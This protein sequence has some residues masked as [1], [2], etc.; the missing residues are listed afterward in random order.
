MDMTPQPLS[1]AFS[2]DQSAGLNAALFEHLFKIAVDDCLMILE[3]PV[4]EVKIELGAQLH[5][6]VQL[7]A[8][9]RRRISE[10]GCDPKRIEQW[11][12]SVRSGS[13]AGALQ[14]RRE[15]IFAIA[16]LTESS[17]AEIHETWDEP[18][19]RLLHTTY[20]QL[21]KLAERM[22]KCY[23]LL[24][25]VLAQ[26]ALKR[27]IA[28]DG[29]TPARDHRFSVSDTLSSV[30][31]KSD[32]HAILRMCHGTLMGTEIPTI[33]ACVDL[34]LEFHDVDFEFVLDM[35]RQTWDEAR[36]ARA[37]IEK[38]SELGGELGAFPT[39]FVLWQMSRSEDLALRLCIHQRIGEWIGVDAALGLV[40]DLRQKND[41][42]TALLLDFV[43][44]DEITHV[45]IGN[46]WIKR[47]VP[48]EDDIMLL[49]HKA[50][51]I[52]TKHNQILTASNFPLMVEACERAGMS[53][54]EIDYLAGKHGFNKAEQQR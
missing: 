47:L 21:K 16:N 44:Q 32:S 14:S 28:D 22:E 12:P 3:C 9:H 48:N 33:E 19:L 4:I 15:A 37:F 49:Q 11:T 42:S 27:K 35:A 40:Q 1:S 45:A 43:A 52:R 30:T 50:E 34:I 6:L 53:S 46:R 31:N 25:L 2:P 8:A 13:L 17:R 39:D 24:P 26:S 18:T 29:W 20:S 36:H 10:L 41:I 7:A 51:N 54:R 38:I 23:S 5:D